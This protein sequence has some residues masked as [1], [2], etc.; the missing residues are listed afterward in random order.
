MQKL[1]LLLILGLNV[2]LVTLLVVQ[3]R[4]E[5]TSFLALRA[6]DGFLFLET[7][8]HHLLSSM[9]PLNAERNR[10]TDHLEQASNE[11]LNAGSKSSAWDRKRL[12]DLAQTHE[13]G[14]LL[15]LDEQGRILHHSDVDTTWLGSDAFLSVCQGHIH[16]RNRAFHGILSLDTSLATHISGTG[17]LV[18]ISRISPDEPFF[19]ADDFDR[20]MEYRDLSYLIFE[21]FHQVHYHAPP[22]IPDSL[23]PLAQDPELMA[24][25]YGNE[26]FARE[27]QIPQQHVLECVW[28]VYADNIF[29]GVIRAG[30][31]LDF[32]QH[33]Q[34]DF[35]KRV[36]AAGVLIILLDAFFLYSLFLARRV[37][38]DSVKLRS[39]LEGIQDGVAIFEKHQPVFGNPRIKEL[40]GE[41]WLDVLERRTV[42]FE[43]VEV[44]ERTLLVLRNA[45]EFGRIFI[46]RDISMENIAEQA[47]EREKRMFS[48][49]KLASV[50][51]HEIRNPL[52]SVSM[53]IQQFSF[54]DPKR[55][56]MLHLVTREIQ[57]LNRVV[58]EFIDITKIP[59]LHI[60]PVSI[61]AFLEEIREW[62]VSADTENTLDLHLRLPEE[63]ITLSMDVE[64]MKDVLM[65]L[66]RN[67]LEAGATS[68]TLTASASPPYV[69]FQLKDNGSGMD[70]DVLERAFELYFT[71]RS[72]GSGLGLP[73]VHRVV[74]AH[75]GFIKAESRKGVGTTFKIY[76]PMTEEEP[77]G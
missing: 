16:Q 68:S 27:V 70:E 75:G 15:I 71:T 17:A 9:E 51:A 7:L 18:A 63:E 4:T 29:A 21:S 14:G 26:P 24:A 19:F 32:V 40:L 54:R 22:G 45:G 58:T 33:L 61:H 60:Q 34:S 57:R 39:V 50:V 2:G 55:Q 52:N 77:H 43:H 6:E 69:C 59:M 36:A 73:A 65:N 30:L 56:N 28:P 44:G 64:K 72:R 41:D 62:P 11:I 48:M 74:T 20:I 10:I 31:S 49:G 66:M 8:T 47:R 13:L 3:I 37:G 42:N 1:P 53:I 5:T 25:V 35:R 38:R 12:Q 76:L 46:V 67:S 23:T